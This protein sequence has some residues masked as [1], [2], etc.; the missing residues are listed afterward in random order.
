MVSWSTD[1][2]VT[3]SMAPQPTLEDVPKDNETIRAAFAAF[4]A[5]GS[6]SID[7]SELLELV[8]SLGGILS[9]DEFQA[10][11]RLLDKDGNGVISYVR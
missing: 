2:P 7:A 11:L 4:D 5:D 10:A 8:E 9:P 3:A 1:V 6:G